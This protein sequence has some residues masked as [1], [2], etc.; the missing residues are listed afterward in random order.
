MKT[1]IFKFLFVAMLLGF[2]FIAKAQFYD[3]TVRYY[4][5][6]GTELTNSTKVWIFMFDGR[7]AKCTSAKRSEVAEGLKQSSTYWKAKLSNVLNYDS[8]FS[9]SARTTYRGKRYGEMKYE[10]TGTF[11]FEWVQHVVGSWYAAFSNDK[12]EFIYFYILNNSEDVRGKEYYQEISAS[13]LMPKGV[14]KD[15][16]Y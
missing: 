6:S 5:E 1:K 3:S 4:I 8:D 7:T 16:L 9:T 15:F 2:P 12:S 11:T 14:N 13:D 10:Q